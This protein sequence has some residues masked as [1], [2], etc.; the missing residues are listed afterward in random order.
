MQ[1]SLTKFIL[2]GAQLG[3]PNYGIL[4]KDTYDALYIKQLIQVAYEEG[5][6]RIDIAMDYGEAQKII[7]NL[8][9]ENKYNNLKIINKFTSKNLPKNPDDIES[10]F[11]KCI[12]QSLNLLEKNLDCLLLHRAKHL[13][14]YDG[15]IWAL[16]KN[17]KD[18]KIVQ[19]IGIS[20][21]TVEELRTALAI[22]DISV[23]QMPFNI[24][25]R[26]WDD[27]IKEISEQKKNRNLQIHVRSVFLQGLLISEDLKLWESANSVNSLEVIDWLKAKTKELKRESIKDMC[28]NFVKSQQWIDGIIIG[29]NNI[30][31]LNENIML[32]K[33]K[34][35]S[36]LEIENIE[37][38]SPKVLEKTLNPFYWKKND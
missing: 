23:I 35:F 7:G 3:I 17:L 20:V 30:E 38:S 36:N 10:Y 29:V 33:N 28:L 19:D 21:Q 11:H 24:L 12:L 5:I 9:K 13:I 37:L 6:S 4:N 16:L 26:R 2:G 31:Q 25:D 32:F 14:E 27:L 8:L 15:K 34:S 1:N 18:N 22:E